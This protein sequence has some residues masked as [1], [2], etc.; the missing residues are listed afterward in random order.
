MPAPKEAR[1]ACDTARCRSVT[2]HTPCPRFDRAAHLE[3]RRRCGGQCRS[4]AGPRAPCALVAHAAIKLQR[5]TC[6]HGKFTQCNRYAPRNT[7]RLCRM[8]SLSSRP[9]PLALDA[10]FLNACSSASAAAPLASR[11]ALQKRRL[12][13][14]SESGT[15]VRYCCTAEAMRS[16]KAQCR[17][18]ASSQLSTDH[19]WT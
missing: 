10:L 3:T 14:S 6:T 9:A 2:Q 12:T 17:W 8:M 15:A 7:T 5:P 16:T 4:R 11:N 13:A 19:V 18:T 1:A